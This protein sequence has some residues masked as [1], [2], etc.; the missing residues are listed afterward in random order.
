M[1]TPETFGVRL[2]RA[3][4]ARGPL[5]VGLDPSDALLADWGQPDTAEGARYLALTT[6][7]AVAETAAAVKVQVAFFERFAA[8]GYAVLERVIAVAREAGVL[9]VADAKR[10]DIGSTNE[11]YAQAWAGEGSALRAD[12]LTLHPYLGVGALAP[13]LAVARA[14]GTG[15]LVLAATSNPEGRSIQGARFEGRSVEAG[16]CAAVAELNAREGFGSVGVV[17]GATRAP[18]G[19]DL[20][21]LGGPVL[22]PGV[23]AQGAGPREV[24]TVTAGCARAS[25][26][27]SVSRAVLGAGPSRRALRQAAER[28]RDGLAEV[29]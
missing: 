18:L 2:A 3:I 11:G 22:V 27:P 4:E 28:W 13:L 26:L 16:V 14:S 20:A 17:I 8:A 5:C 23:G 12:A 6:I 25:V 24:A 1:G 29:L 19:V 9:L 10:G 21:T 15:A 7:E